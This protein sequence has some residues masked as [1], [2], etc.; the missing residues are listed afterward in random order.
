MKK[1]TI[2]LALLSLMLLGINVSLK[3]QSVFGVPV[4]YVFAP[5]SLEGFDEAAAIQGAFDAEAYGDEYKV[6]MYAAKRQY[7]DRKYNI[8]HAPAPELPTK[9]YNSYKAPNINAKANPGN[10]VIAVAAC[11]NEDFEEGSLSSPVPGTITVATSAMVNGWTCQGANN[12]SGGTNG[13]CTNTY[14]YGA[15]NPIKLIAPG[16]AGLTDAII[17]SGYKI[18]SV[19]GSTAVTYPGSSTVT[20]ANQDPFDN[21]GDWFIKLNDQTNGSSVNRI[22]KTLTV[23]SSNALFQFAFISVLEGSHGCCDGG[24][25]SLKVKIASPCT[26]APVTTTCPQFTAAVQA[27]CTS[28][29]NT[30]TY[31]TSPV[32]SQWKYNKWKLNT[33]DLTSYI[34]S[35]VTI[36]VTAFD[37]TYTGHAGYVYFDAQCSPMD[38]LGN[39]STFPAGTPSISLPTCGSGSTATITAPPITGGYTWTPP[40]PCGSSCFT[41]GTGSGLLPNQQIATG[42]TGNWTLTMNPPG[43]CGPIVRVITVIISPAPNVSITT[44]TMYTCANPTLNGAG[45]Q[46]GSGTP[47]SA[48]TPNYTINWSPPPTGTVGTSANTGTFTGLTVGINTVTIIDS[49]GCTATQTLNVTPA[50]QVPTITIS[51]PSGTVIGCNPPSIQ[52]IASNT[53][54]NL[55]NMTYTWQSITTGSATGTTINATAPGGSNTYTISGYDPVANSCI[56]TA[57]ITVSANTAAPAMTVSPISQALT[58]NGSCKTFT[59]VTTTTTNIVGV[60]YS[61]PNTPGSTSGTPLT[62]CANAP[63]TYTAQ[64]CNLINGC[65]SSETVAVTANTI[66][67][68]ITVTPVTSNGFTINCTHPNV[69]MNINSSST[70]APTSYSWTNLT[71]SVTTTPPSGGY[72]VTVPGQYVASFQDGN[73]CTVSNTITI[74]IDTLRPSPTATTNLPSGSFTLNCNPN[75]CLTAS[76]VTNPML[77]LSNYSWTVPPNLTM[78]THTTNVCLA[79][80]TSSTAP[81][82]YTVIAMGLNG[83]IGKQKVNF[84]KDVYVP[85][86]S[87]AFTPTAITCSNPCIALTGVSSQTT[88]VSYTFTSPPPTATATT[89]G[90]L[91]CSNGTYTMNWTNLLN[92]CTSQTTNIIALNTTP[93]GTMIIAPIPLNCGQS[94]ALLTAGTTTTST[95]YSYNWEGPPGAGF[96]CASCYSTAVSI[97]TSSVPVEFGV[98][99]TNTVNGCI[100]TNTLSVV[101]GSITAAFT[102]EPANGFSPLSVTFINTSTLGSLTGGSVTTTWNYANGTSTTI[103]LPTATVA[104]N[105]PNGYA[106][107]QSAGSYTVWMIMVQTPTVAG[108]QCVS[109]ASAVVNVELPAEVIVPNVFTPNGDGV[110]DN[111]MLNTVNLSDISFQVYDRWGVKMFDVPKTDKGNIE[112]DGKNLSNKD[113]PAGTYFY[114]MKATGKDLKEFEQKGTINVYR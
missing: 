83:C 40:P 15:P 42:I 65:C 108:G 37:C 28:S 5:D 80:I 29:G 84:Y 85:P 18:Y 8:I 57:V 77:P 38:I 9:S 95:T 22:V 30:T 59:A 50:P 31:L 94:T 32:N 106:T 87:I 90:A 51:A 55:T 109:T 76:A 89:A 66:I 45:V 70:I 27:G 64:F 26:A 34:G 93:P 46:M 107:Y 102:A 54:T 3:A 62:M 20:A 88:P 75:S 68:T 92:G 111:F 61:P 63:G 19:F 49:V 52:L 79:N 67:P 39:S 100:S 48:T 101:P 12:S 33:L 60:W 103:T 17:G 23:T 56:A 105:G 43:S 6:Y 14:V 16:A 41:V 35:C 74:Y 81:T 82:S 73:F 91:M 78:F 21:Y 96:V 114:I 104:P 58:C 1:V 72:T 7:V 110:N 4:N 10:P 112:W 47:N 71:T 24:G 36:E 98:T 2:K 113:V 86:Y 97:P 53:N 13:N 99:I 44:P 25:F 69:Q 11:Q